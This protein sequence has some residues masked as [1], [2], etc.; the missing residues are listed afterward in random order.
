MK[1]A[2]FTEINKPLVYQ[3]TE[4]P[5]LKDGNVLVKIKAAALNHRDVW[6]RKGQYGGI[7]TPMILG[8]DGSGI[9]EASGDEVII[10]P[11]IGWGSAATHQDKNYRILGLPDYGTFADYCQVPKANVFP[12]PSHL[13][14]EEAA[15]LPL[16]GLTAYR[17]LV[18][19]CQAK[20][21]EKVLISGIGGG[22]AL[23]AMQF[24]LAL[25]CEVWVTSSSQDKIEKAKALGV[26][27]GANYTNAE[28]VKYLNLQTGGFDVV[29]DSAAGDG[30]MDLVKCTRAGARMCFY[31]GTNGNMN[32]INP[33]VIFWKQLTIMGS[34][35]GSE[36][37]FAAMLDFV[38]SHKIKPI[39]DQIYDLEDINEAMDK[40]DKHLQFGKLVIKVDKAWYKKLF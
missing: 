40:M 11:S 26:S 19:R 27:G 29:I 22:V 30:F 32:N 34:T 16:A 37:E 21:G 6:I 12:K 13:S 10:C 20:K 18:T 28:F 31:G 14:W 5:K 8:S 24:A 17:A 39:I 7:E 25:G 36:T 2:I 3:D 1:T 4:K 33:Q 15:A 9:E 38:N 23:F 35:M